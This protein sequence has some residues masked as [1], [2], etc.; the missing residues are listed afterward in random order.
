MGGKPSNPT[1]NPTVSPPN[2][3]AKLTLRFKLYGQEEARSTGKGRVFVDKGGQNSSSWKNLKNQCKIGIFQGIQAS[4]YTGQSSF[5][6]AFNRL[7]YRMTGQLT[8]LPS[9]APIFR[10]PL[11]PAEG[12]FKMLE[13]LLLARKQVDAEYVKANRRRRLPR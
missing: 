4:F 2:Q 12:G 5:L 3:A 1:S 8:L 11:I 10:I 9:S 7:L 6:Q 13:L